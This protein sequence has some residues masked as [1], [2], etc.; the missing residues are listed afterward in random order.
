MCH[1]AG[2]CQD[3]AKDVT[4]NEANN[5]TC[6]GGTQTMRH[7]DSETDDKAHERQKAVNQIRES[8][9]SI[10]VP[11]ESSAMMS[12][13]IV[14]PPWASWYASRAAELVIRPQAS[15]ILTRSMNRP[16]NT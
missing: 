13:S 6:G 12:K 15:R 10:V 7:P 3:D 4:E 16:R 14:R 5:R 1:N 2:E 9:G 11:C 8:H